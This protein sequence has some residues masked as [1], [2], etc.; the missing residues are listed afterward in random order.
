MPTVERLVTLVLGLLVGL[1]VGWVLRALRR[2]SADPALE[3]E[4]R[5]QLAD[6]EALLATERKRAS[7]AESALA[8]A[9]ALN[10]PMEQSNRELRTRLASAEADATALRDRAGA[11][12]LGLATARGEVAQGA[13]L[14]A[15]QRRFHEDNERESRETHS[16]VTAELKESHDRALGE[17][18]NAFAALSADALRQSAPEFLRLAQETFGRFQES[19]KGDL[20]LREER[21]AALVRPL[22]ENLRAY[23]QRLQQAETSQSSALGDVKRHI[24]TL[25][26]QSLTLSQ[27]TQRLR[28]VLSSNQARGRWGEETLRRVV[29]AAGLSTHCDFSEQT[30]AGDGTPD[31]VVRLP[32][33]RVIIVD[34]KVPD[35]DFLAA[36]QNAD[37]TRRGDAL[38]AHAR[39]LRET[40]KALS[41]RDYPRLFPQALDFVVLFLPAESLFSAALEADRDLIVWAAERR[42]LLST[43]ASLIGL[44]RSV[45]VSWQLHEQ[46]VNAREIAAAATALYERIVTFATH[47][48]RM[49]DALD[50][51]AKSYDAAVGSYDRMV[52]PAGERLLRLGVGG[53]KAV[54]EIAALDANLRPAPGVAAGDNAGDASQS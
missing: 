46:S 47:F 50:K 9:R 39:R 43:P 32:G 18:K 53:E 17:L 13:A 22:E 37:E 35:L 51:A 30:K 33:D 27:E 38:A 48:E 15:E 29:E 11:A 10:G 41:D 45:A 23:Q 19:A 28:V 44:L 26:Q 20:G 49:R 34:S 7:D 5:R 25:A 2:T 1:V 12:E 14:L 42:I 8:A 6:R 3:N 24:E 4:L 36:L 16:R 31:L 40:I 52:R 54:P 21:I